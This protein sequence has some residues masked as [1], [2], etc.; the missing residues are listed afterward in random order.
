MLQARLQRRHFWTSRLRVRSRSLMKYKVKQDAAI[1][2]SVI[3]GRVSTEDS[4]R[5][6]ETLDALQNQS[7]QHTYEVVI[8]DRLRDSV[9]ATIQTRYSDVNLLYCA[10]D[11]DL[12]TM[13]A[14]ALCHA[15]GRYVVVTEDHCVPA[16]DWLDSFAEVFRR[17]PESAAVAGCVENGVRDRALDWA[18]FLCEYSVFFPPIASGESKNLAGMNVAYR[19][20]IFE[21]VDEQTLRNGFWE[22][23]LHPVL[24]GEGY[25]L[26][27]SN[28]IRIFHCKRFSFGLF[29]RQRFIYSRYFAGIRFPRERRGMRILAALACTLLPAILTLRLLRNVAGKSDLY[30]H[31]A[32]SLSYLLVFYIAWAAGE[33]V[34]YLAGPGRALQNIE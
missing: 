13:R 24:D 23:T 4:G 2:Y 11:T 14:R 6:L 17:L 28:S 10:F 25:K 31:V 3:I 20:E 9:S 34:G 19:R 15:R 16:P 27:A 8:V 22:T 18:T 7:G 5:I 32:E 30:R 29:F 21:G 1:E 12:P 33:A 26:V